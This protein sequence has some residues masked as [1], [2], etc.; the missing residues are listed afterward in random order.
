[1][2]LNFECQRRL[3]E[4]LLVGQDPDQGYPLWCGV[5]GLEG[6]GKR[7]EGGMEGGVERGGKEDGGRGDEG[8]QQG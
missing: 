3:V 5:K 2:E 1:M 8:E 4:F 7:E 6:R